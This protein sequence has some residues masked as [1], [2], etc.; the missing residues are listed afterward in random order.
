MTVAAPDTGARVLG[1]GAAVIVGPLVG[2]AAE[3]VGLTSVAVGVGVG[4]GLLVLPQPDESVVLCVQTALAGDDTPRPI[5]A[6]A[7]TTPSAV[8]SV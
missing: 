4:L 3:S 6:D 8:A 5:T 7:A 1:L 2:G